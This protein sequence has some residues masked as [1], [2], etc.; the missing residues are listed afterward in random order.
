MG[1]SVPWPHTSAPTKLK[2]WIR[3]C[4]QWRTFGNGWSDTFYRPRPDVHPVVQS[5]ASKHWM[6]RVKIEHVKIKFRRLRHFD[7]WLVFRT[8]CWWSKR[9]TWRLMLVM[10]SSA[11]I[12]W[13]RL[14]STCATN[15]RPPTTSVPTRRSGNCG[16]SVG[17]PQFYVLVLVL[18]IRDHLI[19]AVW[20]QKYH[21]AAS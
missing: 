18:C 2:L 19:N 1:S 10:G 9:V 7:D 6:C 12:R 11:S 4:C 21:V 20:S 16:F 13:W 3:P 14:T 15:V 17:G 8:A 5:T